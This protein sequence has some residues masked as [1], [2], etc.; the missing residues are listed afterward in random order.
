MVFQVFVQ[1]VVKTHRREIFTS[2]QQSISAR[3]SCII[4]GFFFHA[5][6]LVSSISLHWPELRDIK[7]FFVAQRPQKHTQQ[8][9]KKFTAIDF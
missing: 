5:F 7:F 4:R 3:T 9:L 1:Q 2:L 8:L 6:V